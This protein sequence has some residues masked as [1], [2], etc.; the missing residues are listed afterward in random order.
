MFTESNECS[1]NEG[2]GWMSHERDQYVGESLCGEDA[3]DFIK[4]LQFCLERL[5]KG[6]Q[7][8]AIWNDYQRTTD[9]K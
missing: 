7:V 1:K 4:F 2:S 9:R 5:N 6:E 3:E 8:Q